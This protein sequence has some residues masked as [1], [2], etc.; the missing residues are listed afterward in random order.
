METLSRGLRSSQVHA[1]Y[2]DASDIHKP[3]YGPLKSRGFVLSANKRFKLTE[4]GRVY[5]LQLDKV[6]KGLLPFEELSTDIPRADRL[7]RDKEA[8]L[9]R[10][11]ETDAFRLFA[12]GQKEK[13]LD[14]DFYSYLGTTVRTERN[15]FLGRLQAVSD[16]VQDAARISNDSKHAIL[17][18]LH[19]FLLAK[20]ADIIDRKRSK[21]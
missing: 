8:E 13:I 10:A 7:S 14:T 5:A 19:D 16:A 12:L 21:R 20:F 17:L 15:E 1:E 11:A 2:P 3:L 9:R 6:V 18:Q 4:K